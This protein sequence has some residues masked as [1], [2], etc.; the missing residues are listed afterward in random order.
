MMVYIQREQAC[1]LAD[2]RKR[3]R[4]PFSARLPRSGSGYSPQSPIHL[5]ISKTRRRKEAKNGQ[6][7]WEVQMLALIRTVWGS[8]PMLLVHT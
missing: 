8:R 6:G 2:W 5:K 7:C 4:T 3:I 1:D